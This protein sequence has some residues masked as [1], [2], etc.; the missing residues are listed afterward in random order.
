M[1]RVL[2]LVS[3]IIL[4][5][6][7]S[8]CNKNKANENLNATPTSSPSPIVTL[9]PETVKDDVTSGA[10]S[11]EDTNGLKLL[12]YY[13]IQ[14]DAEYVYEGKG[15]E[16]AAFNIFTDFIDAANNK[17]QTRTNNGGTETIRVIEIKDGKVSVIYKINEC[18]Y[19][20]NF[21]KKT[22]TKNETEILLMEPLIKGTEWTTPEGDKRYISA[23][24]VEVDTPSGKYKAIEVTTAYND[25]TTKDY[26]APKVGL[27]KTVFGSG[28]MEV[29]SSLSKINTSKSYT[30]TIDIFY[31]S[32]DEKIYTE[33]LTLSFKTNDITRIVLQ[34]A[35]R[36]EAVKENYL[37]LISTKTKINSLYLGD[38]QIVYV[39]FSVDLVNDMNVGSGYE[40]LVLQ[41]ITNT[42]GNYYGVSKVYITID[43]KPYESGH[44]LMKKG[45]TFKVNMDAVVR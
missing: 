12:E 1:K 13:P 45:E 22:A 37:P 16:Y 28:D 29:S 42:L 23:I 11:E 5:V 18:Y 38:D 25:S 24:D 2:L 9:P 17:I 3:M 34:E 35:L 44:I 26:Y 31:A 30:Q 14:A 19:R 39:D 32:S 20:D 4:L 7:F 40:T 36:Q 8:A 33:P 10:K 6:S 21:M 15:N 41:S 43:S 27:V